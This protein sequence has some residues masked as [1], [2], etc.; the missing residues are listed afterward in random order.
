[1]INSS[2]TKIDPSRKKHTRNYKQIASMMGGGTTTK[3]MRTTSLQ[4]LKCLL[5][6]FTF[7]YK[8]RSKGGKATHS[9]LTNDNVS[10]RAL[11]E[12]I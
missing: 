8:E 9:Y 11:A 7:N 10:H 6:L 1:M 4:H 5:N 12:E 2:Q 3:A